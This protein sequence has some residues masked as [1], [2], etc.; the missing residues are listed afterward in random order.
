MI[1]KLEENND[2]TSPVS[3]DSSSQAFIVGCGDVG[4]RIAQRIG[5]KQ[6]TALVSCAQSQA[7]LQ[8]AGIHTYAINLDQA[9]DLNFVVPKC[10]YY[11][12]PPQPEGRQDERSRH[13]L[14]FLAAQAKQGQ[15][16]ERIVLIST[17]GVY[18][19]QQGAWVTEE[20]PTEPMTGRGQRRLSLEQQWLAYA[21]QN[22]IKM[23]VLRVPGIYSFSR[24][25]KKRLMAGTPVVDP[26]EC[27][28]TNRIH[29]DDLAMICTEVMAQQSTID[30]FNVSDGTPG[31]ISEYLLEAAK[32][33][34]VAAPKMISMAE[35]EGQ[36]SAGM[37]SYLRE[38]R[39]IDNTKLL[40][41]FTIQLQYPDFKLGMK[42]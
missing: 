11:L 16:V 21:R 31:K 26:N 28:Y 24:L 4:L 1:D 38:S 22:A 35:A 14:H 5:F 3:A 7:K 12:V 39:R 30:V 17:T 10:V 37:M 6:V 32:V 42:S 41:R 15:T 33:L 23:S 8:A 2:V 19:D 40:Q 20:M 34:G 29:A 25:P 18:G 13:F 36:V 9:L 27:G